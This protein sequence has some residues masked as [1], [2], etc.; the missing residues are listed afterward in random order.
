MAMVCVVRYSGATVALDS[1]DGPPML[2]AS[3]HVFQL[4]VRLYPVLKANHSALEARESQP[5][6]IPTM[7]SSGLLCLPSTLCNMAETGPLQPPNVHTNLEP[8]HHPDHKL[9]KL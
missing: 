9:F 6:Q 3:H 5:R 4:V 8:H 1:S 2:A 7:P